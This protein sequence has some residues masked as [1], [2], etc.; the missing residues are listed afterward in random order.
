MTKNNEIKT[1]RELL[2]KWSNH[3]FSIRDDIKYEKESTEFFNDCTSVLKEIFESSHIKICSSKSDP[4][5]YCWVLQNTKTN[6]YAYIQI[7]KK[8]KMP[9]KSIEHMYYRS[10]QNSED[11]SNTKKRECSINDITKRIIRITTPISDDDLIDLIESHDAL[12]NTVK[13]LSDTIEK[14]SKDIFSLGIRNKN[15][16]EA[17]NNT[18]KIASSAHTRLIV[19]DPCYAKMHEKD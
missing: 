5:C 19:T 12:V 14:L 16:V 8:S 7:S 10:M 3:V 18:K 11:F 13:N 2:I 4:I 6:Q 1:I 15:T 17:L 9:I